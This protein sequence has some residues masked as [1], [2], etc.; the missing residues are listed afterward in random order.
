MV[1]PPLGL[2]TWPVIK[3]A[4]S[5]ARYETVEAI[6]SGVPNLWR[7]ISPAMALSSSFGMG[8]SISVYIGPGATALTNYQ[9]GRASCR[10]R[11]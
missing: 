4:L 11:V 10:E 1:K 8:D 3:E 2:M 5:E 6:S 9:I 7:G